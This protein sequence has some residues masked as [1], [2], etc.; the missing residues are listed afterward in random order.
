[1]DCSAGCGLCWGSSPFSAKVPSPPSFRLRL[2][3]ETFHALSRPSKRGV[4]LWLWL[5]GR[6]L[7]EVRARQEAIMVRTPLERGEA[8]LGGDGATPVC[9]AGAR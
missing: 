1:M 3:I 8:F 7:V 2:R 4:L 5:S 6:G 9:S